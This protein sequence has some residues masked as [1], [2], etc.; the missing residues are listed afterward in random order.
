MMEILIACVFLAV[1]GIRILIFCS[2]FII[3]NLLFGLQPPIWVVVLV[4]FLTLLL[5]A[6]RYNRRIN[7][8]QALLSDDDTDVWRY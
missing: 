7:E 8:Y 6:V 3:L 5:T 2:P 1:W 4:A